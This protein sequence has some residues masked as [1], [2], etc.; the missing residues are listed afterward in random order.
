MTAPRVAVPQDVP[1][2]VR[3]INLAYRVEDFFVN[4]DRTNDADVRDRMAKPNAAFLVLESAE[5]G[6][7]AAAVYTEIRGERG[8][9][10]MLAVDP[11]A[12]KSG[13]G[14]ALI[15]TVEDRCRAAGC[16]VLDIEIVNLREELPPFY[17]RFGFAPTGETPFTDPHKLK[18]PA[19][20]VVMTK[21][22]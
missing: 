4:G 11:A 8:Y 15:G 13:L 9:F 22:L 7:L 1:E 5:P 14:R 6:R 3:V 18:R 20:L 16:V 17:R 10:G 21:T 19:H 12:Q 2:L